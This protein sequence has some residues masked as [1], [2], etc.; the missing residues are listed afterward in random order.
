[1]KRLFSTNMSILQTPSRLVTWSPFSLRPS[2]RLTPV[3]PRWSATVAAVVMATVAMAA[4]VAVV[5]AVA[6]ATTS[7]LPMLLL[8]VATVAG[9]LTSLLSSLTELVFHSHIGRRSFSFA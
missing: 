6:A 3:S 8:L 2:S 1:M 5:V 9:N 7:L 4:G